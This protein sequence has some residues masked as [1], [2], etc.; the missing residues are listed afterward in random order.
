MLKFPDV[1]KLR[2]LGIDPGTDTLGRCIVDYVFDGPEDDHYGTLLDVKTLSGNNLI[3]GDNL[4][5]SMH[6]ARYARIEALCDLIYKT[7]IEWKPDVVVC[8]SPWLGRNP[9]T[10]AT[11]VETLYAIRQALVKYCPTV[12]LYLVD[13]NTA[14]RSVGVLGG[15]ECK[16]KSKQ[17]V[18]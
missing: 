3:S 7:L 6:G 15:K 9:S 12:K 18:Q 13:P 2:V 5:T 17:L 10:F 4:L 11:L 16:G 14:K 8:E 1:N